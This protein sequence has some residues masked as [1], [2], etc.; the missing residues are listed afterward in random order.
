MEGDTQVLDTLS[1]PVTAPASIRHLTQVDL[2]AYLGGRL[3]SDRLKQYGTHLDS[4]EACRAELED[5]RTFKSELA[6][7]QRSEPALR[8]GGRSK[9]STGLGLPQA[10]VIA[11][12]VVAAIGAT[13]WWKWA[14]PRASERPAAIAVAVA[15]THSLPAA[16]PAASAQTHDTRLAAVVAP[17]PAVARPVVSPEIPE[18]NGEF[19]LLG[20]MG[21]DITETRPEFR[22]Q[23]LVGA[24]RYSVAIVDIRLHPVQR[25]PALHTTSWRP[26]RPLHRGK[27]YIWQVTATLRGGKTVVASSPQALVRVLPPPAKGL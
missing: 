9:R 15:G 26:R 24:V 4:C 5:L 23:K 10:A 22:W 6:G 2:E 3:P 17:P 27:T 8:A 12:V 13:V 21:E 20:P 18:A 25:S 19:A 7:F 1:E 11:A 14:G 16:S